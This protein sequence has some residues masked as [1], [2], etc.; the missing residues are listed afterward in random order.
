LNRRDMDA[1]VEG[2]DFIGIEKE[3]E[4]CKIAEARIEAWQ[5]EPVQMTI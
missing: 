3:S 5:V 2:F 4:Y 1:K